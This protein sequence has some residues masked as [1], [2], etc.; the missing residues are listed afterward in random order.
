MAQAVIKEMS[1]EGNVLKGKDD[2]TSLRSNRETHEGHK[3]RLVFSV[4]EAAKI[5]GLSRPAAYQA[6]NCGQIPSI[7]FGMTCPPKT[8][9]SIML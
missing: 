9:P 8:V 4:S 3:E 5:L 7:R 2:S 6:V 1:T